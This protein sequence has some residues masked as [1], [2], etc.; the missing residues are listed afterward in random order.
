[1]RVAVVGTGIAGNAAAYA[2]VR[3]GHDVAVYE[4]E[5]R[6]GG[7][8]ATV[9]ID[10]AG[11]PVSVDTGFIVYNTLNYPN[12]TALFAHLGVTTHES[13]MSFAISLDGGRYEWAGRATGVLNGLFAQRSNVLNPRHLIMLKE[14]ARFQ[15][16]APQALAHGTLGDRS[17]GEFLA[18]REFSPLFLDRYVLPMGAAIWSTPMKAML[19]FPARQFIQFFVNHK[20]LQFDRPVWRTVTGGSRRYVEALQASFRHRVRLG[21]AVTTVTRDA[22][23]VTVA[24]ATGE[25]QRFDKVVLATHS[26][27]ALALLG[28]ASPREQAILG[29]VRYR[30]N[31]VYLHRDTRLMPRRPA[32]W[33]S[34]NVLAQ[35]AGNG[36]DRRGAPEDLCVT[37]SMNLLQG[38]P[39]SM[40]LFVTLNPPVP[41]RAELVFGQYRYAHP[42]YDAA[43]FAAQEALPGIQNQRHTL[44]CGA[45][46]G[47]G[48]HEDGLVSGMRAAAL[49]GARMP[50][51]GDGPAASPALAAAA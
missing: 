46:T 21:T 20:L 25:A 32:A 45:W 5:N 48:F 49:L 3:A 9:D 31:D 15:K 29:A 36:L 14:I 6:P 26:D 19:D 13:D 16:E 7:H 40:P 38:I 22:D 4:S 27:Q 51:E 1:M 47:Y 34:W 39:A 18:A 50:W 30:P 33:A 17:L 11:T 8:S 28:D 12:L 23:G 41:P 43:A 2:L 10:Y 37:Y 44:F 24:D 35:D 42:Q